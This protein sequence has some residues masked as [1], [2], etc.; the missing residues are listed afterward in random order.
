MICDPSVIVDGEQIRVWFG[1]GDTAKPD[2]GIH[3]QIGYGILRP[4]HA[5]LAR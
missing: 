4:V 2:E 5:T 3:G 1:G